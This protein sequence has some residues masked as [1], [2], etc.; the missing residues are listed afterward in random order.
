MADL[1]NDLAFGTAVGATRYVISE[2]AR[3]G[4]RDAQALAQRR[5][6][7][8]NLQG[9]AHSLV[10][11]AVFFARSNPP[12]LRAV[13]ATTTLRRSMT[14]RSQEAGDRVLWSS[15][16]ADMRALL[17]ARGNDIVSEELRR[18]GP[19]RRRR[20][21]TARQIARTYLSR[22]YGGGQTKGGAGNTVIK[23]TLKL[24]AHVLIA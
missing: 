24:L 3:R 15:V 4:V 12:S 7:W 19:R 22:T 13:R 16:E 23:R 1:R 10:P 17:A 18:R 21:Q 5:S 11:L 6:G 9:H 14:A 20:R 8:N 2:L